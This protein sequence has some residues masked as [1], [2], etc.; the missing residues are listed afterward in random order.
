MSESSSDVNPL[1]ALAEEFVARHRKGERPSLD[2]FIARRPDLADDIRDLFPGLVVMEGV[3]P[4]RGDA[5]G[6]FDSAPT[7]PLKRL[8]DYRILREVGRGGMGVVYEAEQE[9]LGRHVALK[10]LPAHALLDP[11]RLRRF[12]REAKAA[13]RL[14]HTNIVPVYG[15]G[16]QDGLHY[17]VMQFIQG[18]GLDQVLD[19]L[20]QIRQR[21]QGTIAGTA[22]HG[23]AESAA[24][25]LLTGRFASGGAAEDSP[26]ADAPGSPNPEAPPA[27]A[28]ESSGR[29]DTG[30]AYWGSV[31]RIGI[32]TAQALAYAAAQGTLHRDV[33]PS[34]LLLD[35]H[36][37]LWV[38]DFGLAKAADSEDLTHT[39]DIVGTL[40]YMAPERFSGKGDLRS[41][42]Y[43]IGL[44]LY[45]LLALRPAFEASDRQQL[46]HQV[47]HAEP[48]RLRQ[49]DRA[50]PRDLETVVHKAIDRD[51]ARRY[52][53]AEDLAE[54]L[55]RFLD[56]RPIRARRVGAAEK[57]WR[58][59]RRNP[60][61]AGLSAAV[62]LLLVASSI[63]GAIAAYHFR[64]LAAD[65]RKAHADADAARKDADANAGRLRDRMAALYEV[66][67]LMES[68]RAHEAAGDWEKAHADL[69]K[70]VGRMPEYAL[71]WRER[72]ELHYRLGLEEETLADGAR[73]FELKE[74]D[75]PQAWF[76]YAGLRLQQGDVEGYR[77]VCSRMAAKFGNENNDESIWWMSLACCLG[78]DALPGLEAQARRL[79]KSGSREATAFTMSALLA[80]LYYRAGR[81]DEAERRLDALGDPNRWKDDEGG[82]FFAAVGALIEHRSGKDE[83]AEH[84]LLQADAWAS[85]VYNGLPV[86]AK[87]SDTWF[88]I[89]LVEGESLY[90][91]AAEAVRGAGR[92]EPP[93]V[94]QRRAASHE[95]IGQKDG[96]VAELTRALQRKPDDPDLLVWRARLNS[97]LGQ[98]DQTDGD[99]ARF[100]AL[101]QTRAYQWIRACQ[102]K[103][104]RQDRDAAA[105]LANQAL[106]ALS[107]DQKPE[108]CQLLAHDAELYSR[109]AQLRPGDFELRLTCAVELYALN[110]PP[111]PRCV[112]WMTDALRIR[113]DDGDA[114][115]DRAQWNAELAR[116]RDAAADFEHLLKVRPPKA[117][118]ELLPLA[119][120]RAYLEDRDGYF[121]ICRRTR[122]LFPAGNGGLAA[123]EVFTLVPNDLADPAE[124]LRHIS[125]VLPQ[126][127]PG[128]KRQG[129][130][131]VLCA[132]ACVRA[133]RE[134]EAVRMSN[135]PTTGAWQATEPAHQ[136]V[137]ALV[138]HRLGRD[139][140]ARE[141][142][143]GAD[144][145]PQLTS[146]IG[147]DDKGK[148]L[149]ERPWDDVLRILLLRREADAAINA[150]HR[151]EAD[152]CL[153]NKQWNEAVGHLDALLQADPAFWP[154]LAARGVAYAALGEQEKAKADFQKAE[155]LSSGSPYFLWARGRLCAQAGLLD[156]AADNYGFAFN[157][158]LPDAMHPEADVAGSRRELCTELTR[159]ESLLSAVT[160]NQKN[161]LQLRI[162]L[163]RMLQEQRKWKPALAL[164][165]EAVGLHPLDPDL[166]IE[167]GNLAAEL[168]QWDD[169]AAEFGKAFEIYRRKH[170]KD[171]AFAGYLAA[172]VLLQK[173]DADG[174]RQI[175][176]SMQDDYT[177]GAIPPDVL[178][179]W[180]WACLLSPEA[181]TDYGPLIKLAR[182]VDFSTDQL[183]RP[184]CLAGFCYRAGEFNGADQSLNGLEKQPPEGGDRVFGW[185][186]HAMT[187]QRLGRPGDA[188]PWLAKAVAWM[189]DAEQAKLPAG[190][191]IADWPW[192]QRLELSLLRREAEA[193]LKEPP[194][195][196]DK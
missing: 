58:W 73:V 75:D 113:P 193:V 94:W 132:L 180:F 66:N 48:P 196:S 34:N 108:F 149:A 95:A 133:G 2:E 128:F 147:F 105:A 131:Q 79:E 74:P 27:R 160:A 136:L 164:L 143:Q 114:L 178:H 55:Q 92:G 170:D 5:T 123:D 192:N 187:L 106:D 173:G 44:T 172:L 188:A 21:R 35:A 98:A 37:N 15:V 40:R 70:A 179:W 6:P 1:D 42:L 158:L 20:K 77:S 153:R 46:V 122:E 33:K 91:E 50:I 84:Y 86:R 166:R 190:H 76:H 93:G 80:A 183:A 189:G 81:F 100:T 185:L 109:T 115:F 125:F 63:G 72:C 124:T 168:E 145:N 65:E 38:T 135:D 29:S 144:R 41:D 159:N 67:A 47:L 126:L 174:Y 45:E 31:A 22:N 7:P 24:L 146:F 138:Y 163:G 186:F 60:L 137:L 134:E 87:V 97:E 53:T 16:E 82:P 152:E 120:L 150:P 14:H 181:V 121:D 51:P 141:L 116:W 61:V 177:Q 85:A 64:M 118:A 62:A 83:P 13:A 69:T 71:V 17:Y 184:L 96:A 9:S 18:Q 161:N 78:P 12:H 10:V 43:S 140:R 19:E 103:T 28:P 3:R 102:I 4:G 156:Q 90:R 171:A 104:E 56:D 175:C 110:Q 195:K 162:E 54:D 157:R 176:R 11:Q 36:G 148:P 111:S 52:Q 142:L 89:E 167:R 151:K 194:P 129:H 25:S 59:A 191:K 139:D 154:D 101:K 39:G 127:Q 88:F 8:G 130:W 49:L 119:L 165:G 117:G 30:R 107:G 99:L 32:Q 68:G 23:G 169:A 26:V 182:E 155:K 112:E 57:A